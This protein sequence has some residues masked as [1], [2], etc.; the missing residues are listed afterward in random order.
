MNWIDPGLAPTDPLDTTPVDTRPSASD[1]ADLGRADLG[2]AGT[3]LGRDRTG[4]GR[5][6]SFGST[7][8]SDLEDEFWG[9]EPTRRSTRPAPT[10]RA[11]GGAVR[12]AATALRAS[13][14]SPSGPRR[15]GSRRSDSTQ[16]DSTQLG[17]TRLDSTQAGS[18][19]AGSRRPGPRIA[20][21]GV[22]PLLRR[23][24]LLALVVG[25]LVPAALTLRADDRPTISAGAPTV[26]YG[27]AP[28][29]GDV[30]ATTD[31]TIDYPMVGPL[32][33]AELPTITPP[34][35]TE[36][37]GD[38]TTSAPPSRTQ[39]TP[40][41]G[42]GSHYDVRSGD[43]WS[44]IASRASVTLDR[45]LAANSAS[46]STV[47]LVGQ[48]ICLP[49]EAKVSSL[50]SAAAAG[51]TGSKT[52]VSAPATTWAPPPTNSYSRD[53]VIRI[54]RE[55]WPDELEDTAIMIAD[56]ESHLNPSAQN[57]CCV[58]LFQMY[59]N[60]HK[61]WLAALG[62]TDRSQMFDPRTAARAG[63]ALYRRSNS[64]GAWGL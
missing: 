44:L 34:G 49:P 17:S 39:S 30:A 45:L 19:Q 36:S 8:D 1:P 21:T 7:P 5:P 27:E 6:D 22:D 10:E 43:S 29:T 52:S 3:R 33:E 15:A 50:T 26:A 11:L 12:R 13:T 62:V 55:E 53:Q 35:R 63:Y 59:W 57:W 42:C 2:Q 61:G 48:Q 46:T 23:A 9:H 51:T 28:A 20:R 38:A 56:R 4:L 14:D 37:T 47:I 31:D 16:A 18:T 41:V 58:G 60:V 24:G 54:I 64:F 32:A 40:R 25:L